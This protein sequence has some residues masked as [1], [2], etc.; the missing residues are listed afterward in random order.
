MSEAPVTATQ[1]A[2]AHLQ[3]DYL[4]KALDALLKL[5]QSAEN[6]R[7][8]LEAGLAIVEHA[9]GKPT[10]H[11][12]TDTTHSLDAGSLAE[13]YRKLRQAKS[14]DTPEEPETEPLLLVPN[15]DGTFVLES[16][17]PEI[18]AEL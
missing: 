8:R 17:D 13:S 16:N 12:E 15:K 2:K 9:V 14:E 1:V 11:T 10:V 6:E 7:I 18:D 5:A 4:P 3:R